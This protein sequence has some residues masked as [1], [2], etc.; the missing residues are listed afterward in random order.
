M[1]GFPSVRTIAND[2][3]MAVNTVMKKCDV[4]AALGW[5][6]MDVK[7][8]N[9]TRYLLTYPQG[10]ATIDATPDADDASASVAVMSATPQ[11]AGLSPKVRHPQVS[12][13]EQVSQFEGV[14]VAI[15]DSERRNSEDEVSQFEG[16]S[17]APRVRPNKRIRITEQELQNKKNRKTSSA[18]ASH[19]A[20]TWAA[21]SNAYFDT[22]GT[23]PLRDATNNSIMKRFVKRLGAEAPH[24]A[25]H[26][27][28]SNRR[29]HV[30]AK[31]SVKMLL[32]D[33]DTLRTEWATGRTGTDT[34][35]WKADRTQASGNVWQVLID[36]AKAR[37]GSSTLTQRNRAV[38]EE[39]ARSEKE[40]DESEEREP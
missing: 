16:V 27:L 14:S 10:V 6:Q 30:A 18:D 32:T 15:S 9:A 21:Y 19:T 28:L 4:L 25:A 31:H 12:Q 2:T 3:A 35:A 36:E 24:V 26:Y 39:W 40:K 5:I 7:H 13:S 20:E 34:E 11:A 22:H 33:A 17:V 29:R 1:I 38:A 23:E 37:D 8:G